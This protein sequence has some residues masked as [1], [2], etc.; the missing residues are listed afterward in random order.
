MYYVFVCVCKCA[1]RWR[2]CVRSRVVLLIQHTKRLLRIMSFV[3]FPALLYFPTLS[4]KWHDFREKFT[5]H[6][7]CV[8][9]FSTTFV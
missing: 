2:E 1:G 4:Q 3:V 6:K 9:I 8:L 7:M 5:E